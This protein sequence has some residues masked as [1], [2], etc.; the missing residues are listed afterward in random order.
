MFFSRYFHKI[1]LAQNIMP[2]KVANI[3]SKA[4]VFHGTAAAT[5]NGL[6]AKNLTRNSKGRIV[7]KT[8]RAAQLAKRR[9][10]ASKKAGPGAT[11]R[12]RAAAAHTRRV[13]AAHK[14][15]EKRK[16]AL[17]PIAEGGWRW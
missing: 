7:A 11:T 2:S 10:T 9:A 17:E 5:K 15:W 14:A 12:S 8:A 1:I 3:G 4:K 16:G 13:E 6:T